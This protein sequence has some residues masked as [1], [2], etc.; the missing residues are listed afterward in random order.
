MTEFVFLFLGYHSMWAT[1]NSCHFWY[2]YSAH[3]R[4]GSTR[5]V[6]RLMGSRLGR[7]SN[8]LRWASC[9]IMDAMPQPHFLQ[10]SFFVRLCSLVPLGCTSLLASLML[11]HFTLSNGRRMWRMC[12]ELVQAS[13]S[14]SLKVSTLSRVCVY[15]FDSLMGP[16]TPNCGKCTYRTKTVSSY[17]WWF[18]FQA[19]RLGMPLINSGDFAF[20]LADDSKHLGTFDRARFL[21]EVWRNIA[22]TSSSADVYINVW[23]FWLGMDSSRVCDTHGLSCVH[24]DLLQTNSLQHYTHGNETPSQDSS[25]VSRF[26]S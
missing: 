21:E 12:F 2:S 20:A 9:S 11:S 25:M 5:H 8:R 1:R 10:A 4:Y 14:E 26:S 22:S 17:T 18:W 15:W 16:Y 23:V 6:M 19:D 24:A 7:Q 3:C 13:T